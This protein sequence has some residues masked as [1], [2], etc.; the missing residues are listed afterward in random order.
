M[1]HSVD[2]LLAVIDAPPPTGDVCPASHD[3]GAALVSSDNAPAEFDEA[4]LDGHPLPDALPAA[5]RTRLNSQALCGKGSLVGLSPDQRQALI[6]PTL[7]KSW[8]CPTCGPQKRKELMAKIAS[9]RP[10]RSI[11]LTCPAGKFRTRLQAAQAM[12]KAWTRL[13][14]EI[15][16]RFEMHPALRWL[17]PRER[18][19]KEK[20]MR[21][22]GK[23]TSWD[24]PHGFE[25]CLVWELHKNGWPHLHILTRGCFI[26]QKWLSYWWNR[27]GIGP[28]VW[29]KR[30]DPSILEAAHSAK[31][32][33]REGE[34]F[35]RR[36]EDYVTKCIAQSAAALAPLRLVQF[37]KGYVL[38]EEEQTDQTE[39]HDWT[40]AHSPR[41]PGDILADYLQFSTVHAYKIRRC[42]VVHI[43]KEAS[44]LDIPFVEDWTAAPPSPPA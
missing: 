6:I 37:S 36:P 5:V 1:D 29:I 17:P 7:C 18:H 11:T 34:H 19:L 20:A 42:G 40:W 14:A 8:D 9:G 35:I 38:Q 22:R 4:E 2:D 13:A 25:Y 41:A 23:P 32:F 43:E 12:K 24:K 10:T 39:Y 3:Q 31:T 15:R 21:S 16:K 33:G 44:M 28:I 27:L 26:P 30:A